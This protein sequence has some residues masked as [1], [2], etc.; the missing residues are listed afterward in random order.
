MQQLSYDGIY[1]RLQT[2]FCHIRRNVRLARAK[3]S[4]NL[5]ERREL[6]DLESLWTVGAEFDDASRFVKIKKSSFESNVTK[7]FVQVRYD[8]RNMEQTES[9]LDALERLMAVPSGISLDEE[10]EES[11]DSNSKL[12]TKGSHGGTSKRNSH[13]AVLQF[14]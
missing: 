14:R 11:I 8:F 9:S 10:G 1:P 7:V 5:Q 6:Y 4:I 3:L 12:L 13:E 2:S